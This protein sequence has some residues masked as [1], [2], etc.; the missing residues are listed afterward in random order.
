MVTLLLLSIMVAVTLL[1]AMLGWEIGNRSTAAATL[2]AGAD[3]L[4]IVCGGLCAWHA[5]WLPEW[6]ISQFACY[7]QGSWFAPPAAFL[8]FLAARQG[9]QRAIA[10][11]GNET[12][13]TKATRRQT[14]LFGVL[15]AVV[16]FAAMH[17][18]VGPLQAQASIADIEQ[19]HAEAGLTKGRVDRDGVVR[20]SVGYTCGAAACAT[21]LRRMG[22][23]PNATEEQ[24]VKLCLTMRLRGTSTLGM[25]VGLKAVAAPRGWR[26]KIVE[27]NWENFQ[28]LRTP[29]VCAVGVW[30]I[31]HAVVV[32][33][34]NDKKGIQVA[35]PIGGLSWYRAEE[36]KKMFLNE[37]IVVFKNDPY[38]QNR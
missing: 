37:A 2:A 30:N 18:F 20:Q 26:V 16:L 15:A 21:L 14:V 3:C 4:L 34:I 1:A 23:D 9:R 33:A 28:K 10:A 11:A 7:V 17:A 22:I 32:C 19:A 5:S 35:D 38:E 13:G 31:G 27:P 6:A 36:F 29:M 8:F 25:A 12:A 24:M